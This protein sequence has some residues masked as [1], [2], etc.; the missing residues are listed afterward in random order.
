MRKDSLLKYDL[1]LIFA[2]AFWGFTFP[3]MKI[4]NGEIAPMPFV[5][6][7]FLVGAVTLTW[8]NRKRLRMI[9]RE[10]IAPC[11]VLGVILALYTFLQVQ[12]LQ[13]TSASNSGFITSTSVIFVPV[14]MLLFFRQKP[15]W[16]VVIS[17][18]IVIVGILFTSGVMQMNPLCI[19]FTKFNIGDLLTLG[20]AVLIAA[21]TILSNRVTAKY[22]HALVNFVHFIFAALTALLICPFMKEKSVNLSSIPVLISVLYCGTFGSA[23][24]FALFMKGESKL[25]AVKVS[26][27]A[28]L[29]PVF[30]AISAMIIP[31][32]NGDVEKLT[33]QSVAGGVLILSGVLLSSRAGLS[34]AGESAMR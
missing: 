32:L 33:F 16:K 34:A 19:R 20:A 26:I 18:L 2:A 3:L 30:A 12:G 13:Y 24:A 8:M 11:A 1:A 23:V 21:Y 22:D 15:G 31:D 14:L 25:N 10:M 9:R 27:Y 4:V 29:E 17:I 5:A 7:R 6:L 28:A